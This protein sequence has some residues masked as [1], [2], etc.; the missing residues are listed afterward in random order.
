MTV[1]QDCLN[2]LWKVGPWVNCSESYFGQ[3]ILIV[4]HATTN[5]VE[6]FPVYLYAL[7][8][9]QSP[10][11]FSNSLKTTGRKGQYCG[12]STRKAYPE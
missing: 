7:L 10:D 3:Y 8:S 5:D 4:D 9:K 11:I 1:D 2:N 6:D 12:P